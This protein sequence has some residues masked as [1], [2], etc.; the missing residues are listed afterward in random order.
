MSKFLLRITHHTKNQELNE[1]RQGLDTNPE[2]T[3]SLKLPDKNFKAT[4]IKMFHNQLQKHMKQ[5]K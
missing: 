5:K 2:M 3:E 4:I 1:K